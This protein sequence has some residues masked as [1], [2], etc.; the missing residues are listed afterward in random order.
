MQGSLFRHFWR[1]DEPWC[2][3]NLSGN[4]RGLAGESVID[5]CALPQPEV[6]GVSGD[7]L[8]NCYRKQESG[9]RR[10]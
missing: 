1:V 3:R 9:K 5:P 10:D 7:R 4:G 6:D 8:N 2:E